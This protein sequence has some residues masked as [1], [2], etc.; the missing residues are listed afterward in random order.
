MHPMNPVLASAVLNEIAL[1]RQD[2]AARA[3]AGRDRSR[4][5]FGGLRRRAA[6]RRGRSPAA[7]S[8]P[9]VPARAGRA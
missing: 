8:G 3:I 2:A 7:M 5:P 6:A 4:S 1:Q 9:R